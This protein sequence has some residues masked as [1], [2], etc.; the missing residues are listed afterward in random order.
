M[1]HNSPRGNSDKY[2][3]IEVD[4]A[5]PVQGVGSIILG[6]IRSG[7]VTKAQKIVVYP[8]G[9]TGQVRS[10]QVNDEE[11]KSA[12][13]GTHVGLAMKGILPRYL[14]RGTVIGTPNED[15][16]IETSEISEIKIKKAAFGKPP[17]IGQRIHVVSG[18][19]DSPGELISW[20]STATVKTDKIIPYHSDNRLT[21][22]DLNSKP[23]V[24]A[25][26]QK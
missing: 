2:L 5:F 10:V 15:K 9:Q 3:A 4:H 13:V 1:T 22:L 23:A 19:Y 26:K 8:S 20:N 6:T 18:L 17:I 16:V 25:S 12:S 7:T 14:Q 21:I 11:V 24:L